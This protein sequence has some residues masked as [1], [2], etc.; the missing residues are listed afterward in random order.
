MI[1]I[2]NIIFEIFTRERNSVTVQ[3]RA[4]RMKFWDHMGVKYL[5]VKLPSWKSFS[6]KNQNLG[7]HGVK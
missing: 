6:I 2:E 5:S 3:D 1:P 7:S 4:K